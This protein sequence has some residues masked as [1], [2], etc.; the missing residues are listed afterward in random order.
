MTLSKNFISL[1]ENADIFI[2]DLE[3]MG[4]YKYINEKGILC[5]CSEKEVNENNFSFHL[6]RYNFT[7]KIYEKFFGDAGYIN[8]HEVGQQII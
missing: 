8:Y 5:E 7:N 2:D 3:T 4:G 1:K 6:K